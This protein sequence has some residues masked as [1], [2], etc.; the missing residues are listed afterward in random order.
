MSPTPT[1]SHLTRGQGG[2]EKGSN[3][4]DSLTSCSQTLYARRGVRSSPASSPRPASDDKE[5]RRR[6]CG[7]AG[8]RQHQSPGDR[9]LHGLNTII[10]HFYYWGRG[11]E[12]EGRTA[13][14]S[15]PLWRDPHGKRGDSLQA[16][17]EWT[18]PRRTSGLWSR[19]SCSVGDILNGSYLRGGVISTFERLRSPPPLRTS[20]C[21][22]PPEPG[23]SRGARSLQ[24]PPFRLWGGFGSEPV[25]PTPPG[26]TLYFLFGKSG[27]FLYS[28]LGLPGGGQGRGG[29]AR[30]AGPGEGS[31]GRGGDWV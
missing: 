3:A 29:R 25:R 11:G 8:V 21:A 1:L 10:S 4:T 15:N 20:Q 5:R 12:V 7:E 16:P 14:L 27:P 9:R 17:S 28:S 23:E 22:P 18:C 13:E 2:A 30:R 31:A 24:P 19:G 6:Q 26:T